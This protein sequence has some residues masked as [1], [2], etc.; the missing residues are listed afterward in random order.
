MNS[1]EIRTTQNVTIEYELASL[2]ERSFAFLID[3]II[4]GVVYAIMAI[5]IEA[6]SFNDESLSQIFGFLI[7]VIF[8]FYHLLSEI[9]ADGQSF[10]KKALGVKVVRLDGE[11]P[12]LSDFLL[13][14]VLLLVDF[15]LSL[16]VLAALLISSSAKNQRLGDMTAN[17]TVIR[18]KHNLRFRL[19]DI[20]KINT[21]EE[22]TPQ[23]PDV[24]KLSE[25]DMLLIKNALSRY[26][27]HRNDAHRTVIAELAARLI[28][29][30]E[31]ENVKGNNEEFLKTLIRD[32][33]VLTR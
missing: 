8:I 7:I 16:G 25:E 14:A 23:Y 20:L 10:G 27:T 24:K 11:E 15:L 9:F 3:L 30:L 2:R 13:R 17:T 1:I 22:Y 33:I 4:I 32:Y 21:I 5:F 6:V 18:L 31:I 29:V 28:N 26:R 19:E 12:G